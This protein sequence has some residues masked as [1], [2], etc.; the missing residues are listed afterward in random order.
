MCNEPESSNY[1]YCTHVE[2]AVF[3]PLVVT[4][5]EENSMVEVCAILFSLIPTER[6]IVLNLYTIDDTG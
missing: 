4:T 1:F 6:D 2:I 5:K 3:L